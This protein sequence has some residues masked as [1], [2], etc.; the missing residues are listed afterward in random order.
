VNSR[1]KVG[2]MRTE[3]RQR[4]ERTAEAGKLTIATEEKRKMNKREVKGPN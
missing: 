1:K 4:T 3:K 2:K